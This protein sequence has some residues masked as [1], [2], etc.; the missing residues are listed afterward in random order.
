M[1]VVKN[2]VDVSTIG[3]LAKDAAGS[4]TPIILVP[5]VGDVVTKGKIIPVSV[6]AANR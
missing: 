5:K 2:K 4:H 3:Q 6:Q 1:L